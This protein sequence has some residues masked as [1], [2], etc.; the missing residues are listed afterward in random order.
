MPNNAGGLPRG[1]GKL[2]TRYNVSFTYHP[3]PHSDVLGSKIKGLY[4]IKP[5]DA[6]NLSVNFSNGNVNYLS[7]NVSS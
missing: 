2:P 1:G 3:S 5:V 7:L 4:T 6:S